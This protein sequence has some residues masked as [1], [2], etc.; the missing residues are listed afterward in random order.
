MGTPVCP[1]GAGIGLTIATLREN[2]TLG[3]ATQAHSTE[4]LESNQIMVGTAGITDSGATWFQ[5][6]TAA[7]AIEAESVQIEMEGHSTLDD[8]VANPVDPAPSRDCEEDDASF[9]TPTDGLASTAP[10]K[11]Q[12]QELY[13]ADNLGPVPTPERDLL[14]QINQQQWG[15]VL[16]LLDHPAVDVD[17][18]D[19]VSGETVLH[20]ASAMGQIEIVK[21][22]L[23]RAARRDLRDELTEGT[24]LHFAAARGHYRV[25]MALL[26]F[27]HEDQLQDP[28][29]GYLCLRNKAGRTAGD[30]ANVAVHDRL[31]CHLFHLEMGYDVC[32]GTS[33]RKALPT[34]S[35]MPRNAART[36]VCVEKWIVVLLFSLLSAG[37]VAVLVYSMGARSD[38]DDGKAS[39]DSNACKEY[40]TGIVPRVVVWD[41][42]PLSR[43]SSFGY[44]FSG[45]CK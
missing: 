21:K 2:T 38:C 27:P 14:A 19:L 43:C 40:T 42:L 36:V 11:A 35:C 45:R 15:R 30:C 37:S 24:A 5:T 3:S 10:S 31:A 18:R 12:M 17:Q 32:T 16:T 28:S 6:V 4:V 20:R 26:K 13:A 25:C 33:S 41:F 1:N 39:A 7:G 9:I 22:L 34:P 44:S 23:N 8:A 29:L